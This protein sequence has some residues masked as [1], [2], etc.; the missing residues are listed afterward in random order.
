MLLPHP[1]APAR[2]AWW[3]RDSQSQSPGGRP[4]VELA[5]AAHHGTVGPQGALERAPFDDPHRRRHAQGQRQP[6]GG[7]ARQ[8]QR[9]LIWIVP[10]RPGLRAG[11]LRQAQRL[12]PGAQ[13]GRQGPLGAELQ[14]EAQSAALLDLCVFVAQGT[15]GS[16]HDQ[17][18]Q[19]D[20]AAE[21]GQA[22]AEVVEQR[23]ERPATFRD[24]WVQPAQLGDVPGRQRE[25]PHGPRAAQRAQRP[26]PPQWPQQFAQ[27]VVGP[28]RSDEAQ[29]FEARADDHLAQ[30]AALP[31][32]GQ[33]VFEHRLQRLGD[34]P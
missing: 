32:P 8:S 4:A 31:G 26:D 17:Q 19:G 5:H 2:K 29:R 9:L 18:A 6:D 15:G 21:S 14:A 30:R 27:I 12:G 25:C 16:G 11:A 28:A 22:L 20:G 23:R 1:E 7:H 13:G 34:R 3:R 24:A 33:P 10:D